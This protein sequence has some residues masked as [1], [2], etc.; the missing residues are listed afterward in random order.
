MPVLYTFDLALC[1]KKYDRISGNAIEVTGKML[2]GVGLLWAQIRIYPG[3]CPCAVW[4]WWMSLCNVVVVDVPVQCGGGGCPCAVWWWWIS[5]CNVVVEK[6][7]FSKKKARKI[8]PLFYTFFFE[9][10]RK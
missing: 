4:W 8:L 10:F 2:R 5:L 3:G 1:L 6:I 9:N 7:T